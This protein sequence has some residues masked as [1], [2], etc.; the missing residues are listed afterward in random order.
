MAKKELE[1][2][3]GHIGALRGALFQF[4]AAPLNRANV[5][6]LFYLI[7]CISDPINAMNI[8]NSLLFAAPPTV[9]FQMKNLS[10]ICT[11]IT[12]ICHEK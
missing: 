1:K 9:L 2:N 7:F 6:I 12:T 10:L 5:L 11:K 3:P 8:L 4:R